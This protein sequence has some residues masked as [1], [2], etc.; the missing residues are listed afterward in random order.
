MD[1]DP[2]NP[3]DEMDYDTDTDSTNDWDSAEITDVLFLRGALS[4]IMSLWVTVTVGELSIRWWSIP[5][6]TNP[7]RDTYFRPLE[8]QRELLGDISEYV[9][10]RETLPVVSL[11][12][13]LDL[14]GYRLDVDLML[15]DSPTECSWILLPS[16]QQQVMDFPIGT[17]QYPATRTKLFCLKLT[18]TQMGNN[19]ISGPQVYYMP[20][21]MT[22]KTSLLNRSRTSECE[23]IQDLVHNTVASAQHVEALLFTRTNPFSS[24][25]SAV[26]SSAAD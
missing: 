19:A 7:L 16:E 17:W 26:A 23:L 24:T 25:T 22:F 3:V 20:I 21:R 18:F 8:L 13:T 1:T 4:C 12:M 11:A 6:M 15:P 2:A 9:V 10:E 5:Q 14:T